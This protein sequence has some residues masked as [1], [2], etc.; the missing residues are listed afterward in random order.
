MQLQSNPDFIEAAQHLDKIPAIEEML[1]S[2]VDVT[3]ANYQEIMRK[4]ELQEV[5][6]L[7]VRLIEPRLRPQSSPESLS[8]FE[9]D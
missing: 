4:K 1:K 5:I 3:N 6:H 7:L 2:E 9:T 8:F